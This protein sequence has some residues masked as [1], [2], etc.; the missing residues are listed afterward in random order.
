MTWSEFWGDFDK[1]NYKAQVER[2]SEDEL[3][4]EHVI[5]RQKTMSAG[6]GTGL[7]FA[8]AFHT[9]GASLVAALPNMRRLDYNTDKLN[10]IESR[11]DS[12][13]WAP[14][15]LRKRDVAMGVGP[16][17]LAAAVVPGADHIASNLVGHAVG[18]GAAHWTS[19]HASDVVS[20]AVHSPELFTQGVQDG[21]QT[22]LHAVGEAIAGHPVPLVPVDVIATNTP[23]F[24]GNAAGQAV[25]GAAEIK[26]VESTAKYTVKLGASAAGSLASRQKDNA[27]SKAVNVRGLSSYEETKSS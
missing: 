13:G 21:V 19:T 14:N 9:I 11:M 2:M 1:G 27:K 24:A 26:L 7:G 8:A 20:H 4:R 3:R 22:Q 5:I 16:S 6:A 12:K 25:T 10:I 23:W 15:K 18:H 17:L